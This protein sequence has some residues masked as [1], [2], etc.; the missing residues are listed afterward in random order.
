V[1]TVGAP[2]SDLS[3]VS[4][5]RSRYGTAALVL[6]ERA[7]WAPNAAPLPHH[8]VPA[9]TRLVHVR[10]PGGFAGAWGAVFGPPPVTVTAGAAGI[11]VAG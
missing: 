7:A 9:G 3:A 4:S 11:G 5:L 2:A 6:F 10:T 1:T 8:P